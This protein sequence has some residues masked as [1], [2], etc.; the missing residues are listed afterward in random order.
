MTVYGWDLSNHDW[1]RALQARRRVDLTNA[2]RAGISFVTHKATEGDWYRDPYFGYG[3]KECPDAFAK[4]LA[5]VEF[6]VEGSYHV[7]N[8]GIN[9]ARQTD[10]WID[11]VHDAFPS[12]AQ[13]QCWV[14]QI[15]AEPLDGYK[16]PTKA[17]IVACGQRIEARLKV[18]A[19]QILVY[20]PKW[21][22]GNSLKGLPYRLW[23]S[24]Y[25]SPSKAFESLYPGDKAAQWA[26]YSGQ[27]PLVLQYSSKAKIGAQATCDANAIRVAD[28]DALLELFGRDWLSMASLD[29]LRKVVREEIAAAQQKPAGVVNVN[30]LLAYDHKSYPSIEGFL[31]GIPG[32][33]TIAARRAKGA[34]VEGV[35][36]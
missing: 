9:V 23:A 1:E 31:T 33:Q 32:Y 3:T 13:R 14:W 36:G 4:Q 35:E 17:E 26:V 30:G 21:V 12:W 5:H 16:A 22:Y 10:Y 24:N 7:L 15:D 20:G 19:A 25:V 11:Y 34:R 29:D 6:P 2:R 28:E 27:V 18:P 8:H